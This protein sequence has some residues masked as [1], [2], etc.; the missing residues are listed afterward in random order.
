MLDEV[1]KLITE[2]YVKSGRY[3]G[4]P[5]RKL[6]KIKNIDHIL[7]DLLEKELI[8]F[9]FGDLHPNP[10]VKAFSPEPVEI[11]NEKFQR[12]KDNSCIYPEKKHLEK[13]VDKNA[14]INTPYELEMM[15]G[16]PEL[17]Y[18]SFDLSVLELY[19][20]D[21]R[22]SYTNDDIRGHIFFSDEY[23]EDKNTKNSDNTFLE[24]FG[25]SYD[26]DLNRAVAAYV[27]YLSKLTP[28]HQQFWKS[29]ELQ[30]DYFLHPDYHRNTMG[31][32]GE[33]IPICDAFI[34][35]L[36]VINEMC[37]LMNKPALFR[38]DF[39]NDGKPKHFAFLIRPTEKE[40]Y[41]FVHLLDKMLADNLNKEFFKG[42]LLLETE[43]TRDDGKIIVTQK[44]TLQLLEEWIRNNF[45]P[46]DNEPLDKMF[47]ALKKVR[48]E[49]QKPAHSIGDDKF[50]NSIMQKQ[51]HLINDTYNA[52]RTIRLILAN[53]PKVKNNYEVEEHLFKG[54]IWSM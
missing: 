14:Y 26:K 19:R 17:D 32:W 52:I 42:D 25:F 7:I 23:M 13:I 12:L 39:K 6:N 5:Y 38:K 3:N 22:Y 48:K 41:D 29:K 10:H 30:G 28:E 54:K 46:M 18:R 15:M 37:V 49:R 21:P 20:N 1:L 47:L 34:Q 9:V 40:Y 43:T 36:Q 44:G 51:R 33:R 31:H 2:N 45:R 24:T 27:Y 35:E 4:T 50:D 53:H 8:S 11:Q 16:S